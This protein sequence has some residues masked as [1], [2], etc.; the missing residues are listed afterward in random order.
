MG[1]GSAGQP[2]L[3]GR[4]L[5]LNHHLTMGKGLFERSTKSHL[6]GHIQIRDCQFSN[7]FYINVTNGRRFR[8]IGTTTLTLTLIVL[9]GG[10][11]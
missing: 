11:V 4:R 2:G 10:V 8:L 6:L 9:G 1:F 5:R 3:Q 7:V